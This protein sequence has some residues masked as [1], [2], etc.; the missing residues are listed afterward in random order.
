MIIFLFNKSF[1]F[2][3]LLCFSKEIILFKGIPLFK[4]G[5]QLLYCV[6]SYHRWTVRMAVLS[7]SKQCRQLTAAC[8]WTEADQ[9]MSAWEGPPVWREYEGRVWRWREMRSIWD[10][11]GCQWLRDWI[12]RVY[13]GE[14]MLRRIL[15]LWR[16]SDS[17]RRV[18]GRGVLVG[19]TRAVP[20]AGDHWKK[21][22][23]VIKNKKTLS[24]ELC[25]PKSSVFFNI[26]QNHSLKAQFV[27]S[28]LF[29]QFQLT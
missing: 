1:F 6:Y 29:E 17:L 20:T 7:G 25:Q 18:E 3:Q 8:C 9:R 5:R 2:S 19:W 12:G 16:K 13:T 28:G 14:G 10:R 22:S 27:A 26:Y 24:Y 21:N 23:T 4:H 15:L 11:S